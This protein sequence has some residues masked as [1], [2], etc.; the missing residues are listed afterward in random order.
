MEARGLYNFNASSQDELSFNKGEILKIINEEDKNWLKAEKNGVEGIVPA[1]HLIF[2]HPLWYLSVSKEDS[3]QMLKEKKGVSYLHPEGSFLVRP[4]VSAPGELSL[5][6]RIKEEIQHYKILRTDRRDKY[7][8]WNDADKFNSINELVGYYRTHSVSK[9]DHVILRDM[10]MP[11]FKANYD[12]QA[13]SDEE[14][15]LAKGDLVTALDR[16]DEAWWLGQVERDTK[17]GKQS[18]RGLFPAN[19]VVAYDG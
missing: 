1:N 4:S 11:K 16:R 8:L 14:L 6:I 5:S 3:V 10:K 18:A 15:D 9:A 12:F 13:R 17:S 19:Y 2:N 7:F